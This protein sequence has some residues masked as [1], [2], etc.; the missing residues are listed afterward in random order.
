MMDT[1]KPDDQMLS[2]APDNE[3]LFCMYD[4]AKRCR[5]VIKT[6]AK[7]V[8]HCSLNHK[9]K[10]LSLRVKHVLAFPVELLWKT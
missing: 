1:V 4:V 8:R 9:V 3:L 5:I 10:E 7:V 6:P 2:L